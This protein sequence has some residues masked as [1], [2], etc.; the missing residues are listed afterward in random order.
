M[1]EITFKCYARIF[2]LNLL[3]FKFVN[4]ELYFV[5]AFIFL[6][7]LLKKFEENQSFQKFEECQYLWLHKLV[8][9]HQKRMPKLYFYSLKY[10]P[11]VAH[12]IDNK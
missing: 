1:K 4:F 2:I 3:K 8:F 7:R 12:F 5:E 6:N 9:G 11:Y 10:V